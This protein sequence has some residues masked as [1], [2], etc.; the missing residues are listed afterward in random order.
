MFA[1]KLTLSY[2]KFFE[3]QLILAHFEVLKNMYQQLCKAYASS[4]SRQRFILE[5]RVRDSYLF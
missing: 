1:C 5:F 2:A 4:L 3:H